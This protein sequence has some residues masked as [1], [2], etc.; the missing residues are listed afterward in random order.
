MQPVQGPDS[1][2]TV[3]VPAHRIFLGFVSFRF[4]A[5][6]RRTSFACALN[7]KTFCMAAATATA[8]GCR[9]CIRRRR[10]DS[11]VVFRLAAWVPSS[12]SREISL[13]FDWTMQWPTG[14][15]I[16]YRC[17]WSD[18]S[19][20]P[21]SMHWVARSR[22]PSFTRVCPTSE[23]STICREAPPPRCHGCGCCSRGGRAHVLCICQRQF[24]PFTDP[25]PVASESVRR[26]TSLCAVQQSAGPYCLCGV[27]GGIV[28]SG[29][30]PMHIL[31]T[32]RIG[33]C[34][35]LR[36]AGRP[37][38]RLKN[39]TNCLV[40]SRIPSVFAVV[41][42]DPRHRLGGK[43]QLPLAGRAVDWRGAPRATVTDGGGR[44]MRSGAPAGSGSGR[45]MTC[46]V[47]HG[48]EVEETYRRRR[49]RAAGS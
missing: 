24:G 20:L 15:V 26:R 17:Q 33:S 2:A 34:E 10:R 8:T 30:W 37:R 48:V 45:A 39:P 18:P 47:L 14:R 21:R 12:P 22:T 29:C 31:E 19:V 9:W 6:T 7:C 3:S 28:C 27:G 40:Y 25:P 43:M 36:R 23:V 1:G 16:T 42:R 13:M 41:L 46:G 4:V 32:P 35:R 5:C 44:A 49:R 11:F 38:D